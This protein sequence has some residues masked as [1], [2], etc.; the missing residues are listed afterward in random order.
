MQTRKE[1]KGYKAKQDKIWRQKE[2]TGEVRAWEQHHSYGGLEAE[3]SKLEMA[4]MQPF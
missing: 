3:V 2:D 1:G 4:G